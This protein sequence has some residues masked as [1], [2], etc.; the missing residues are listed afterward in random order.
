MKKRMYRL[1][2]HLLLRPF[3][4]AKEDIDIDFHQ[5]LRPQLVTQILYGCR[6]PGKPIE[7]GFFLDLLVSQRIEALLALATRGGREDLNLQVNCTGETCAE[8]M[9]ID[10]SMDEIIQ[11][12]AGPDGMASEENEV[13]Q[14]FFGVQGRFFK[15]A[16]GRRRQIRKPTGRDQMHWLSMSF[17]DEAEAIVAMIK[18]LTVQ[19]EGDEKE[20]FTPQYLAEVDQL[21][22]EVD[23]LVH[24]N[25]TIRC[26]VCNLEN[27]CHID[28]EDLLLKRLARMQR[29]LMLEIHRLA[30]FYH[31]SEIEILA[32]APHRRAV[33]LSLIDSRHNTHEQ[34]N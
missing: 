32:I 27:S 8:T 3:G 19:S 12:A 20:K 25:L 21:M 24:F 15:K 1:S 34:G 14:K 23:P 29:D 10:L 18:T 22:K 30:G 6:E 16:P 2:D 13:N 28:L 33:Y 11:H 26:P 31:W 7:P 4:L 9:E 17:V 5:P